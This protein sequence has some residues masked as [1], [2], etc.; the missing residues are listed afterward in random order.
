MASA[1]KSVLASRP[2]PLLR[3]GPRSHRL[4]SFGTTGGASL[5][6]AKRGPTLCMRAGCQDAEPVMR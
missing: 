3:R 2:T 1:H 5:E 4:P 6:G